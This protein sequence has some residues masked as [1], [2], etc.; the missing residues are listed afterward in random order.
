MHTA[1]QPPRAPAQLEPGWAEAN[2]AVELKDGSYLLDDGRI[3]RQAASCLVAPELGDRVLVAACRQNDNYIVHLLARQCA[4][5]A[6]VGVP[7]AQQLTLRQPR[8]A[9]CASERLALHS[10]RDVELTAAAGTL[11]LSARNLFATV[12]ESLVQNA[13]QYVGN[14][15]H[16][17]LQARQILRLHGKQAS[18]TAEHDVKVDAE[19]ISLG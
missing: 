11:S 9:L 19:R 14:V 3:A 2:V 1:K 8:I 17:L 13:R 5:S 10:A 15:E 12:A 18:I 4:E 16:Y 6:F 7:G